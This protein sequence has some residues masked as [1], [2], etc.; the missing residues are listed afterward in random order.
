M[1]AGLIRQVKILPL[2][3]AF[4]V[5]RS[6]TYPTYVYSATYLAQTDLGR[7]FVSEMTSPL[8]LLG[9]TIL[10]VGVVALGFIRW[11]AQSDT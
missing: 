1:A 8:M 5:G 11:K 4:A 2:V 6:I 7:T 9:Q 3:I 10:V